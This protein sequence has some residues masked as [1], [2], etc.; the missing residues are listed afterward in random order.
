MMVRFPREGKRY[1]LFDGTGIRFLLYAA[2]IGLARIGEMARPP[3]SR[4]IRRG[5]DFGSIRSK[6]HRRDFDVAAQV[7]KRGDN[8]K[9]R[10][11]QRCNTH[12]FRCHR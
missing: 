2:K 11:R 1:L 10:E 8:H 5:F 6:L 12:N 9:A 4:Q 3:R 7:W